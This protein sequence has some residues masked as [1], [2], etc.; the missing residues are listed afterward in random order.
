VLI[1]AIDLQDG[2]VVQL[3]QGEKKALEFDSFEPWVARFAPYPMVQLIDLD[4]AKSEGNNSDL[5]AQISRLLPCQV[6][7]GVR[8]IA[9]AKEL[10]QLG[11][12]AIIIGSSLIENGQPNISFARALN[13][14]I[15]RERL[16]FAVDSRAG[17]VV[18]SGWREA[19]VLSASEMM[20]ALNDYCAAFLYTHVDTEGTMTGF[21]REIVPELQ[22]ATNK[23]LIVAGGIRELAEIDDLDALGVDAVV[24]MA[25]YSGRIRA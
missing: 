19:S 13:E 3:V 20:R 4:A 10:L 5:V 21:P 1:P 7:G 2:A 25:I 22:K 17:K 12:R 23:R 11:A 8:T 6:G 16:I 15:E 14:E 24:G 18:T 9:R